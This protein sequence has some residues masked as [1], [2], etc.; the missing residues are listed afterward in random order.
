MYRLAGQLGDRAVHEPEEV[1]GLGGAVHL[2]GH[3]GGG[4]PHRPQLLPAALVR[5]EHTVVRLHIPSR[6]AQSH[7]GNINWL[8]PVSRGALIFETVHGA[9]GR[10]SA[11]EQSSQLRD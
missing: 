2:A 3:S 6:H 4:G 7:S 1:G 10:F 8:M 11:I 9:G 5:G